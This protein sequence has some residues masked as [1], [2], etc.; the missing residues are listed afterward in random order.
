MSNCSVSHQLL[1]SRSARIIF[2][3]FNVHLLIANL[4]E[5]SEKK[6]CFDVFQVKK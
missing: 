5:K 4:Q 2:L 6:E 1:F 3:D